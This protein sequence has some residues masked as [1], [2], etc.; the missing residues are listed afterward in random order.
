MPGT[1]FRKKRHISNIRVAQSVRA[2]NRS[3]IFGLLR[4]RLVFPSSEVKRGDKEAVSAL[5]ASSRIPHE[6][7]LM[8]LV[9]FVAERRERIAGELSSRSISLAAAQN[10]PDVRAIPKSR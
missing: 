10:R 9:G 5:E 7:T 2:S 4:P 8:R 1:S 3:G 6:E